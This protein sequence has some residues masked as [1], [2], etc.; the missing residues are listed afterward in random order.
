MKNREI[1]FYSLLSR[2]NLRHI[3][4]VADT[5]EVDT[6]I[7]LGFDKKWYGHLWIP[8]NNECFLE[9]V[10]SQTDL[11]KLSS[12]LGE[13]LK[14]YA[15]KQGEGHEN[16]KGDFYHTYK[17]R[18]DWLA[19]T[20]FIC[21]N[22]STIIKNEVFAEA[23]KWCIDWQNEWLET[24]NPYSPVELS[25]KQAD[26]KMP[27]WQNLEKVLPDEAESTINEPIMANFFDYPECLSYIESIEDFEITF[28]SD[29]IIDHEARIKRTYLESRSIKVFL[30]KFLLACQT[31]CTEVNA[32]YFLKWLSTERVSRRA[33]NDRIIEYINV[34]LKTSKR[35]RKVLLEKRKIKELAFLN[36]CMQLIKM[37][38]EGRIKYAQYHK[39]RM[40]KRSETQV[41]A[42]FDA[43]KSQ[44]IKDKD[45]MPLKGI[46]GEIALIAIRIGQMEQEIQKWKP[47]FTEKTAHG[48]DNVTHYGLAETNLFGYTAFKDFL[49]KRQAEIALLEPKQMNFPEKYLLWVNG[50]KSIV[51]SMVDKEASDI[52]YT[53]EF[54]SELTK[55]FNVV[56]Q[57]N[58]Y[59]EF[60]IF[61]LESKEEKKVTG[62]IKSADEKLKFINS[63]WE[64]KFNEDSFQRAK[65][66]KF[67]YNSSEAKQLIYWIHGHIKGSLREFNRIK[68]LYTDMKIEPEKSFYQKNKHKFKDLEVKYEDYFQ[69]YTFD[70]WKKHCLE[71]TSLEWITIEWMVYSGDDLESI[72]KPAHV[73]LFSIELETFTLENDPTLK[74]QAQFAIEYCLRHNVNDYDLLMRKACDLIT[75][76][77][78]HKILNCQKEIYDT[79]LKYKTQYLKD[80]FKF[81][82]SRT[83]DSVL[84]ITDL[85][86]EISEILE[87][88]K[89]GFTIAPLLHDGAVL[90][91]AFS[92]IKRGY[93]H[94]RNIPFDEHAFKEYDEF[95]NSGIFANSHCVAEALFN[96]KKYLIDLIENQKLPE[97][98]HGIIDKNNLKPN[99]EKIGFGSRYYE[100][101]TILRGIVSTANYG[102]RMTYMS[103]GYKN[104][105]TSDTFSLE[106][107]KKAEKYITENLFNREEI[108]LLLTN[109]TSTIDSFGSHNIHRLTERI[110]LCEKYSLSEGKHSEI[111]EYK[112]TIDCLLKTRDL[113]KKYFKQYGETVGKE[114]LIEGVGHKS[115]TMV[116]ITKKLTY[117]LPDYALMQV[118]LSLSK[119]GK[120]VN[121][122]NKDN[123]AKR[124]GYG[125]HKFYQ[126]FNR[127]R[128]EDER[129]NLS[130]SRKKDENKKNRL[131]RVLNLLKENPL[132]LSRATDEYKCFCALFIK[133]YK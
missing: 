8:E 5:M 93:R 90:R 63:E 123:I 53:E 128:K 52:I 107:Y 96:F 105:I 106:V 119:E 86:E 127:Y 10:S 47:I 79:H 91:E 60:E 74:D 26:L 67:L 68:G 49:V 103:D 62:F 89:K 78:W 84:L 108:A 14:L 87:G 115:P 124:Y 99:V 43:L 129:K 37:I 112:K 16:D 111:L 32:T 130:E 113:I 57:F 46:E 69:K 81:H 18:K 12:I 71:K 116:A 117:S 24:F 22:A 33:E 132:A 66:E 114:R 50:L 35:K 29:P 102:Y 61:I 122:A 7:S 42:L 75:N 55:I 80:I 28:E 83:I 17:A 11:I 121:N 59:D 92:G 13:Q 4:T 72:L 76:E 97:R 54:L 64:R 20:I 125:G 95:T 9:K 77:E 15:R 70:D 101:L 1:T 85:I 38:E 19:H 109:L 88:Q 41:T 73:N 120:A 98:V 44:Y 36:H 45:A 94:T 30:N 6:F 40:Q 82:S 110:G 100:P 58:I 27:I 65:D 104:A 133:Q 3:E 48:L 56:K 31:K 25:L 34:Q 51:K 23:I 21:K 126:E 131:E 2:E 118:Y 39:D